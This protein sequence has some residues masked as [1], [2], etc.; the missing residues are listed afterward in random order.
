MAW[1]KGNYRGP[2]SLEMT[3]N[4][5]HHGREFGCTNS[6]DTQ[7]KSAVFV[8]V[9]SFLIEKL[10]MLMLSGNFM[11]TFYNPNTV[12]KTKQTNG[13][14]HLISQHSHRFLRCVFLHTVCC[15]N[16]ETAFCTPDSSCLVPPP[17]P[18][19][20]R[21]ITCVVFLTFFDQSQWKHT[22]QQGIKNNLQHLVNPVNLFDNG[23]IQFGQNIF[24]HIAYWRPEHV[25]YCTHFFKRTTKCSGD[26]AID[27]ANETRRK[28]TPGNRQGKEKKRT[29]TQTNNYLKKTKKEGMYQFSWQS[30]QIVLK[31]F[32]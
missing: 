23:L 15:T 3:G 28:H 31:T 7:N 30:M 24:C 2:Q 32:D 12:K 27:S 16:L 25:L 13:D 21:Q 20:E 17:W 5:L 8:S 18:P 19:S 11:S 26:Q 1:N 10:C 14:I 4:M 22:R 6:I 9:S 29:L